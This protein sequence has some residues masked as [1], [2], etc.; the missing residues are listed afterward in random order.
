MTLAVPSPWVY[1]SL[2]RRIFKTNINSNTGSW[3]RSMARR[4]RRKKLALYPHK[5]PLTVHLVP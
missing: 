4:K 5:P 1:A 2:Q 3:R